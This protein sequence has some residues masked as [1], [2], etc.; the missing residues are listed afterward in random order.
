MIK[1]TFD[2][3]PKILADYDKLDEA[4]QKI[5]DNWE[6]I[7]DKAIEAQKQMEENFSTLAGDL[8]TSL[9]DALIEAWTNKD[10]YSAIDAFHDKV[11]EAIADITKQMI[12]A[13]VFKANFDKAEEGMRNS[14]GLITDENGK[15]RQMTDEE[16]QRIDENGRRIYDEDIR[17]NIK[18]L[19]EDI[20]A[21]VAIY[22]DAIEEADKELKEAGFKN[23]I[24]ATED[25][26]TTGL[27]GQ[28]SR[29]ITE[30]TGQELAGLFRSTRDDGRIVRDLT[31]VGVGHLLKI[32]INT[33][34]TVVGIKKTL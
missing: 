29:S 2:L 16:M 34:Q 28:I 22:G 30:D 5:V 1:N 18:T 7:K 12:F 9:S 33:G 21:G 11:G 23:G 6:E 10:L 19:G 31:Q 20:K 15:V 32:E 17:D 26:S 4:T 24:G 3:N 27:V 25:S 13:A 8:G 14:F